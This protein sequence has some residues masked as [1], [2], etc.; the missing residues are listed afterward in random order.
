MSEIDIFQFE[1]NSADIKKTVITN[2]CKMFSE[3]KLLSLARLNDTIKATLSAHKGDNEYLINLD[4]SKEKKYLAVKFFDTKITALS[5]Y[6]G[7]M[8][9][10]LGRNRETEMKMMVLQNINQKLVQFISGNFPETE[11]FL[12]NELMHNLVDN[13][14]VP[15]YEILERETEEFLTFC[16]KYNCKKRN[17]P[18]LFLHDPMARYY[19]LKKGDI[20]RIIR[21]SETSGYSPFYRLVI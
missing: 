4:S 5:A 17:I 10:F 2:V 14:L 11:L 13:I 19:N 7:T 6:Y 20:V 21:P 16:E 12:E 18:K 1:K 9:D 3:R 15:K 8:N